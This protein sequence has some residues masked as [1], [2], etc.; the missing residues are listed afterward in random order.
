M[1]G[2]A[3]EELNNDI[4]TPL[5]KL[6]GQT[7]INSVAPEESKADESVEQ[8]SNSNSHLHMDEYD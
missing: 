2:V 5:F 6:Q 8:M 7:D 3:N 4:N 1:S